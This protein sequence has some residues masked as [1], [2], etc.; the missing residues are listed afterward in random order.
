MSKTFWVCFS[1]VASDTLLTTA[2][3]TA[4]AASIRNDAAHFLSTLN[5]TGDPD[6]PYRK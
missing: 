5:S 6:N 3:A 2:T 4:T 1:K